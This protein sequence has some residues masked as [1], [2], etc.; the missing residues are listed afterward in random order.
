MQLNMQLKYYNVNY[1]LYI[2]ILKYKI[3]YFLLNF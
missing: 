2:N 1:I 3:L